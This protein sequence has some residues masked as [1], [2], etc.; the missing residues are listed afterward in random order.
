MEAAGN[1]VLAPAFGQAIETIWI[2]PTDVSPDN[3]NRSVWMADGSNTHPFLRSKAIRQAMSMAIDTSVIAEQLYGISGYA[4]C[5]FINAPASNVSPN[6]TCDQDIDGAIALLDEAGIVDSDGDG[7]REFEGHALRVQYQTSTNAVRQNT[8]AL[9][10]QWWSEIGIETE[11]RNIAASVYFGGDPASPD[12]FQKFYSD[13]EMYTTGS[14]SPDME[15]FLGSYRCGEAPTPDNNWTGG[16]TPRFCNAEYDS[17]LDE[18]KSTAGE[19]ARAALIIRLND[20]LVQ[21]YAL[22]PLVYR[23]GAFSAYSNSLG[24]VQINGWD[25]EMWNI[26]DWYRADM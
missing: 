10:K 14:S 19:M 7:V 16:N 1:G 9:I 21:E 17:I 12:T 23:A 18:L 2:N 26:E 6:T 22:I 5:N 3:P 25:S 24:G 8:Q 11:L 20:I 15:G 13:T 4:T